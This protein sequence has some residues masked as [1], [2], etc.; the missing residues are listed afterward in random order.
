M[1][2]M[3]QRWSCCFQ[4]KHLDSICYRQLG[5]HCQNV[6]VSLSEVKALRDGYRKM[7]VIMMPHTI[8]LGTDFDDCFRVVGACSISTDMYVRFEFS[9]ANSDSESMTMFS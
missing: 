6:I 2:R 8:I 4:N 1:T 9:P 5:Y 7:N 3:L